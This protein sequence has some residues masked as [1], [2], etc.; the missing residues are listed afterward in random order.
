MNEY[1]FALAVIGIATDFFEFNEAPPIDPEVLPVT[2]RGYFL[3]E[4]VACLEN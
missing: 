2:D 4:C 1:V 3:P